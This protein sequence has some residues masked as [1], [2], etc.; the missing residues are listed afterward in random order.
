VTVT[1]A[2]APANTEVL[3]AGVL[4]GTAPGPVQLPRGADAVVLTFKADGYVAMSRQVTPDRD[5]PLGVTLKKRAPASGKGKGH[6]QGQGN[7][8]RD[9]RDDLIDVFD[10]DKKP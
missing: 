3:V 6:G 10:K 1:I 7:P 2:G 4:I 9:G 5:Q 8:N